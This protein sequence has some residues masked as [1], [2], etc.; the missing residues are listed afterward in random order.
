MGRQTAQSDY[1]GGIVVYSRTASYSSKGQLISD[2]TSTKKGSDT[3]TS[4][5]SYDYGYGVNYALGQVVSS[6]STNYKN[7]N[8]GQAPDTSTINAYAWWDGAVQSQITHD[9]DT[10]TNSN[11]IY[12]TY[13]YYD[14]A[15]RLNSASVGDYLY[16]SVTFTNDEVG[17]IIRRDESRP[18][19]APSAQS[20]SPHEVWYRYTGRQL[21]YTGNNGS[22]D[23]STSASIAERQIVA[24]TPG[25]AGTFRNNSTYG[26]SYAD[27]AQ[28]YDPL[29]SYSQG[30]G[31][32][33][34]T[35]NTGDT[36]Q[37]IAQAIYGDSNLWYKIA[38]ANG[39][40]TNV[41][42]I[43]GQTLTLP[44]G[45]ARNGYSADTMRPYNPQEAIGDL[46]P[47]NTK[48]PKKPKC[49][50]FGMILLA[51]IAIAVTAIVA[52]QLIGV[53]AQAATVQR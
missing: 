31:S 37:S 53:A 12:Y 34:Y 46:S 10:G 40:G 35:V 25:N 29:N 41:S 43:E 6:Y 23:I 48:P 17:Q 13:F 19:T 24:P 1:A 45:V 4:S 8:N 14:A 38:E 9:T 39:L 44:A 30:A 32:G 5:T 47:T 50:G 18:Y 33:S 7:G 22:N 11:P 20:G 28:S 16:R 2:Y 3:F 52:S 27:F 21:G 42:L 51:V 49:G 36:L 15:G 26:Q